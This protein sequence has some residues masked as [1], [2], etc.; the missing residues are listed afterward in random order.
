MN[1]TD[2]LWRAAHNYPHGGIDALAVRMG[3]SVNSLAHKVK[4]SNLNAHCSP[5]EMLQICEMTGDH[6]AVH[7]LACRL[8]YVLLPMPELA[9]GVDATFTVGLASAVQEFGQFISEVSANLAD[10]VVTENELRRINKEAA[11][12]IA[13]AQKLVILAENMHEAAKPKDA[14]RPG[15]RAA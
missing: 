6:G 11:E 7:A 8:G 2:A 4:P 15:L 14:G 3:I 10:G 1:V 13:A 9:D 12:M 5:E